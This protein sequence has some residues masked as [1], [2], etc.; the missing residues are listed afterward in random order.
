MV[1]WNGRSPSRDPDH[2]GDLSARLGRSSEQTADGSGLSAA[3][4]T[5]L[6][7]PVGP[8]SRR[9]AS[10]ALLPVRRSKREWTPAGGFVGKLALPGGGKAEP[11]QIARRR[12]ADC[13][14]SLSPSFLRA[15]SRYRRARLA[16][17]QSAKGAA[18]KW[19]KQLPGDQR[20]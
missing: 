17:A 12:V 10:G 5:A 1:E 18:T 8:K 6:P 7:A 16:R 2:G 3:P 19:G 14:K 15:R 4:A 11:S 20:F 9:T 13:P